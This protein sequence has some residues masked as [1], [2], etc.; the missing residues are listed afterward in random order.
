MNALRAQL[1]AQV[2]ALNEAELA[3]AK[4]AKAYGSELGERAADASQQLFTLN[5]AVEAQRDAVEGLKQQAAEAA[6]ALEQVRQS[7]DP[8]EIERAQIAYDNAAQS[9]QNAQ[10]SLANLEMAQQSAQS[11]WSAVT[12]EME[13]HDSVLVKLLG[14]QEKFTQIVSGLPGPLQAAITGIQGMTGA[15]KA[16][17][18]TPLGAVLAALI[19][20]W[21]SLT[22]W[23]NSSAEGQMAFAK[24]SGYTSGVLNQ[25]KEVAIRVGKFIYKMFTDPK[26]AIRQFYESVK[27]NVINRLKAVGDMGAAVGSILKSAFTF[28]WDGVKKGLKDLL[29]SFLQF[30]TGVENVAQRVA[31]AVADIHEK[32][33]ENANISVETKQLEQEE[34]QW[35]KR[36]AELEK[37]KAELS[38]KMYDTSLSAAERKKAMEEYTK[39]LDEQSAKEKQ[40]A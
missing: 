6:E 31:N 23:F 5:N 10:M 8:T 21:Q 9:L 15:A 16:F 20:A 4:A 19:L 24:I 11:T 25:L 35:K 29:N 12:G 7:S 13:R 27:K 36:N 28:N 37:Q 17:I 1:S 30:G 22:S 39:V 2:G 38:R 14:G 33:T 40:Y 3:A 32:A 34:S 26:E 18:A